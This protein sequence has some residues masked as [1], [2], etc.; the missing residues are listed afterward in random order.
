MS[1][2]DTKQ[3]LIKKLTDAAVVPNSSIA[4]ENKT[5]DPKNKAKWLAVYFIPASEESTG[6]SLASGNEQRGIFQVSVFVKKNSKDFDNTQ[7][8][9]VDAI[10]SA[11]QYST[12][13]VYNGQQIDI[14]ESTVNQGTENESWFKRDVSIN[15]LT[16]SE[17]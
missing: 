4:F 3:A 8:T 15:Y 12:S 10:K 7:L 1:L 11:F 14:L 16:F 17:K 13:S 6:K 2:L 9:L 5:F